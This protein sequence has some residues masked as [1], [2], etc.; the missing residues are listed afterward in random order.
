MNLSKFLG[1]L[2]ALLIAGCSSTPEFFAIEG[3]TD[4]K[5][6]QLVE[7][8]SEN[9]TGINEKFQKAVEAVGGNMAIYDTGH[10]EIEMW[11]GPNGTAGTNLTYFGRALKCQ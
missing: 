10:V 11:H 6:I 3:Y 8:T 4:C 9:E 5:F 1:L 7:V 2:S